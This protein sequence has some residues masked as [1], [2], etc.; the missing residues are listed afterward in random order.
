MRL[1]CH[2]VLSTVHLPVADRNAFENLIAKAPRR[3]VRLII[4]HPL[5]TIEAYRFG[6]AIH[7]G[8]FEDD[9]ER[10]ES[11]SLVLWDLMRRAS[12]LGA[13]WLWFDRDEPPRSDFPVFADEAASPMA[14]TC[15]AV[16]CEKCRSVD[17]LCD[18]SVRWDEA[19]QDWAIVAVLDPAWCDHCGDTHRL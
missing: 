7:L 8:I 13:D 9:P 4:D 2:C 18:A 16:L 6:F 1:A 11:V 10:P 14:P 19:A 12:S 15:K 5:L 3:A 17:L